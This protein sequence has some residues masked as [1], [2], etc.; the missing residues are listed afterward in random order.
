MLDTIR[1]TNQNPIDRLARGS[2]AGGKQL[3]SVRGNTLA[4]GQ[5]AKVGGRAPHL[6]DCWPRILRSL[7]AAE[8]LALFLDFD[9]TLTPI[10]QRPSDV[11]PLNLRMRKLLGWLARR[12][13]LTLHIISGR[14]L[15]DLRNLAA[16]SGARLLGLHGWEG[17]DVPPLEK[18]RGL[19]RKA[20]QVILRHVS[21]APRIWIEDKRLG[22]AVHY[23]NAPPSEVRKGL[24]AVREALR[25]AGP[26]IHMVQG[27]KIW[28]LLPSQ[29]NGKGSAVLTLLAELPPDTLPIFVGD[30]TTDE[31]A[32]QA[33][34]HGLTIRVGNPPHTAA[35]FCLK[36]PAEV[37]EFL[38][39]L[40]TVLRTLKSGKRE[41]SCQ[42]GTRTFAPAVGR[43]AFTRDN[44]R[45][46]QTIRESR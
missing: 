28:E 26:A 27:R 9:G 7:D 23:R 11:G 13:N 41:L 22:L 12:Q 43:R 1:T 35:R 8:R 5:P 25:D 39:R 19:L 14:R 16:V 29:I 36:G 32:F 33:L 3:K 30:D 18:E 24:A 44:A 10:R 15:A 31:M 6:F 40:K 38:L 4:S 2:D 34:P 45:R 37:E 17:R 21:T 20:R 46:R 42:T